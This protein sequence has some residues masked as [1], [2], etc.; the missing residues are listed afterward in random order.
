[1]QSLLRYA[2]VSTESSNNSRLNGMNASCEAFCKVVIMKRFL[3]VV[4]TIGLA[5]GSAVNHAGG[6]HVVLPNS[7]L[8]GC[9]ASACSQMWQ[10]VSP[11]SAAIYPHNISIDIENGAVLGIV[12]HYEKSVSVGDIK[13]SIDGHYGKSTYVIDNETSPVKVWRVEP[14]KIAIQLAVEDDGKKQVI[15][16]SANAWRKPTAP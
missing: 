14:E 3:A 5:S 10:D 8:I 4:F 13:A 16:L 9:K 12:A 6:R 1:M 7:K 2:C 11:D 15:Y